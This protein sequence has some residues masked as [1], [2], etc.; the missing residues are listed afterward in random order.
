MTPAVPFADIEQALGQCTGVLSLNLGAPASSPAC[1]YSYP[2][3]DEDAGAPRFISEPRKRVVHIHPGVVAVLKHHP[4]PAVLGV[5][6]PERVC[7]LATIELLHDDLAGVCPRES[8]QVKVARISGHVHPLQETRRQAYHS[9]PNRGIRL[10]RFRIMI[11]GER[12][13]QPVGVIDEREL[14]DAAL[15]ELEKRDAL[16]IGT[17]LERI[18][19]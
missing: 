11:P 2:I 15:V 13:I 8:R 3:A 1:L 5:R 14:G 4:H 18:T 6:E 9:E 17:P 10:A 12:R 16:T 19:N 7:V